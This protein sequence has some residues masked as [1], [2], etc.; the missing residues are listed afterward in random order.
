MGAYV[1]EIQERLRKKGYPNFRTAETREVVFSPEV[2]VSSATRWM[3]ADKERRTAVVLAPEFVVLE[4][5]RYDVFDSFA[6]AFEKILVEIRDVAKV[7]LAERLGLRYVD[8]VRVEQGEAFEPLF[9]QGLHGVAGDG[10]FSDARHR[11]EMIG[12]TKVGKLVLR[13]TRTRGA[14]LPPDLV[15]EDLNYEATP[16]RD[17]AVSILDIDHFSESQR[18][19][20]P[21]A[22]VKQLWELHDFTDKAFR[23]AV[24][25]I[26]LERWGAQ[27]REGKDK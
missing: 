24:T 3:F 27:R 19:F 20:E 17:E 7:E 1:P 26:A 5:S 25:P 4:T 23:E 6:D 11:Y 18:D 12:D 15:A 16:P 21:T 8:L 22:L 10:L 14:W 13:L 9:Q 2:K